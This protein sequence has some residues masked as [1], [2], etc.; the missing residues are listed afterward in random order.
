MKKTVL[1]IL[2][3][4]MI[5]VLL[6]QYNIFAVN[7]TSSLNSE[8]ESNN[9]QINN[10]QSELKEVQVEKS[11]AVKKKEWIDGAEKIVKGE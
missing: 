6:L 10:A 8:K 11:K 3:V 4:A 9:Q 5:F 1:Q 2:A 7:S